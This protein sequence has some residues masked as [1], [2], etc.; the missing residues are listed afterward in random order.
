MAT[1]NPYFDRHAFE[2][3]DT[4]ILRRAIEEACEALGIPADARDDREVVAAR[5]ADL[6]RAGI[7]DADALRDRVI[8][9]ARSGL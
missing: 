8:T 1:F 2:P 9:E 6:A 5:I 4:V 7:S 3:V